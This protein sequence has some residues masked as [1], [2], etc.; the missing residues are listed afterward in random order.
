MSDSDKK[1]LESHISNLFKY[2]KQ[3]SVKTSRSRFKAI[4]SRSLHELAL[5]DIILFFGSL[6][7]TMFMLLN[8]II[9]LLTSS[10]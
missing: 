6:V 8:G 4:I 1:K 2:N 10:R 3:M 5:R 9:K 7:T